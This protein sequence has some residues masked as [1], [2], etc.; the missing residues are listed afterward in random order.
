VDVSL[1]GNGKLV[2]LQIT[3]ALAG[4]E[5]ALC[6]PPQ[7]TSHPH[8]PHTSFCHEGRGDKSRLLLQVPPFR[9]GAGGDHQTQWLPAAVFH[10]SI[11]GW[12]SCH[13]HSP[14]IRMQVSQLH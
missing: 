13:T 10:R 9:H 7:P 4:T 3:F 14:K 1:S 5:P 11:C 6:P 12:T 2:L 8:S